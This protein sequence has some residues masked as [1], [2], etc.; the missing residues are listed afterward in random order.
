LLASAEALLP[1]L[2]ES[3]A[4]VLTQRCPPLLASVGLAHELTMHSE[5]DAQRLET[6]AAA[7]G[8]NVLLRL[9]SVLALLGG[10]Q[11]DASETRVFRARDALEFLISN[12][13]SKLH[14]PAAQS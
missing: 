11:D 2:P 1:Y 3:S 9:P 8:D 6:L 14:E 13:R 12:L 4:T 5:G 10:C 7:I